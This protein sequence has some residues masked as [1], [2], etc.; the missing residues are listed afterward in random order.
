MDAERKSLYKRGILD[1]RHLLR[2]IGRHEFRAFGYSKQLREYRA[3]CR[4]D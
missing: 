3:I 2:Q 4:A 1:L